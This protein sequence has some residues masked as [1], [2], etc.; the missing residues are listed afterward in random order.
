[1]KTL[2]KSEEDSI[3]S[4]VEEVLADALMLDLKCKR[5]GIWI[6]ARPALVEVIQQAIGRARRK[7]MKGGK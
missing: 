2:T 3:V 5:L 4:S 7:K 1:M 6:G